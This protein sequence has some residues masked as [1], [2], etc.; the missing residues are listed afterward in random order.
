MTG[1]IIAAYVL[2]YLQE[3][4]RFLQDYRLLIYPLILIFIMLFRP[5]G[6][7]GMKELSFVRL[8]DKICALVLRKRRTGVREGQT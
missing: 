1:S 5:Q 7:L 3:F 2:T 8:W 4:L 6:L